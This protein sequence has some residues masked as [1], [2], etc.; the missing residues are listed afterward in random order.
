MVCD[1]WKTPFMSLARSPSI[2]ID[3]MRREIDTS[4]L[5]RRRR[6]ASRGDVTQ[7]PTFPGLEH[8]ARWMT[9]ASGIG[10][11]VDPPADVFT[12]YA[13]RLFGG[14]EEMPTKERQSWG[15]AE[16]QIACRIGFQW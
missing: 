13:T 11:D 4:L 8:H 12:A 1:N 2:R 10:I 7:P 14:R 16:K 6:T 9:P 3:A 15:I 5:G